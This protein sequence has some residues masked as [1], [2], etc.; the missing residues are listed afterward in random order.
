MKSRVFLIVRVSFGSLSARE[1]RGTTAREPPQTPSSRPR[2]SP[3]WGPPRSEGLSTIVA[4]TNYARAWTAER[5]RCH[6]FV[7]GSQDGHPTNC[8]EPA[9]TSSGS[10]FR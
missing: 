9:L 1:E 5:G 4:V 2:M 10:A 7:H 6:R 8:P 3:E